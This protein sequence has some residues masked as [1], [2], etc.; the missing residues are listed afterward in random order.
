MKHQGNVLPITIIF[1]AVVSVTAIYSMQSNLLEVK[2]VQNLQKSQEV[3]HSSYNILEVFFTEYSGADLTTRKQLEELLEVQ[4]DENGNPIDDFSEKSL[5]IP[6]NFNSNKKINQ[7]A[8]I[9]YKG[10]QRS[11][12]N[13]NY[14]SHL[15]EIVAESTYK[16]STVDSKQALVF[17]KLAPKIK[18]KTN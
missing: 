11:F 3:Y 10:H 2:I 6:S 18:G 16:N 17:R 12:V 13:N 14:D 7:S 15:F 5:T 8:K 9:Q 1:L 4:V